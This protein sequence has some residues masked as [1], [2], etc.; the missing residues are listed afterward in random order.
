[1]RLVPRAKVHTELVAPERVL[2]L[3][4]EAGE[5]RAGDLELIDEER[6][7]RHP[8]LGAAGV[9]ELAGWRADDERAAGLE[10]H[11]RSVAIRARRVC[12]LAVGA[13]IRA[14]GRRHADRG[15]SV[16]EHRRD[17][18]VGDHRVPRRR[19]AACAATASARHH[20]HS[21]QHP[22]C[23]R[24]RTEPTA[25]SPAR[26][27]VAA[28]AAWC[29]RRTQAIRRRAPAGARMTTPDLIARRSGIGGC[30]TAG[31]RRYRG[32]AYGLQSQAP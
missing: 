18:G 3:V 9:V 8:S 16:E 23:A 17:A 25:R 5:L 13:A 19:S 32:Q 22:A 24:H 21:D 15:G 11:R 2:G 26:A 20:A 12:R 7:Q 1:V 30:L 6:R 28:E 10:A 31:G 14:R 4:E 29:C 27:T